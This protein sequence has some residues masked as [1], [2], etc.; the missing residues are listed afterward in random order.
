MN[1]S[2]RGGARGRLA[3]PPT[4]WMTGEAGAGLRRGWTAWAER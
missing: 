2:T 3:W 1:V 4:S